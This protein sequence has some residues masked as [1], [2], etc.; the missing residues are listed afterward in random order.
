MLKNMSVQGGSVFGGNEIIIVDLPRAHGDIKGCWYNGYPVHKGQT[1]DSLNYATLYAHKNKIIPDQNVLKNDHKNFIDLIK[2]VGFRLHILPFPDELNQ[3][4]SLHH[5]AIFIRDAGF[6]YKDNWIKANFS[7]D[8]RKIEAQ[9]HAKNISKKFNKKIIELPADAYIEF[10]EVFFIQANDR[11]YYFGGLSRSN[12][13]GHEFMRK[14]LKPDHFIL[15]K[16]S[17]YHLDTVLS[18][19]LNKDNNL[20]GFILNKESVSREGLEDLQSLKKEIIYVNRKDSFGEGEE[21]GNYTVNALVGPGLFLNSGEFSTPGV[22][23]KLENLGIKY[24]YSPLTYFRFAGG[25]YHCLTNEIY[26]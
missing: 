20:I 24:F 3:E 6:M 2:R 13:K 1:E 7:V 14:I 8:D 16:S 18:P 4:N 26:K 17:G 10:G 25:S 11:S 22:K 21:L 12:K 9:I 19:L 5:D 15:I 23:E